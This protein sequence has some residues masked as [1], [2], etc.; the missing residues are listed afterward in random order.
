[1]RGERVLVIDVAAL[2][3]PVQ[4]DEPC[5]TNLEYDPAFGEMERSAVGRPEQQFGDKI[6]PGEEPLWRDVSRNAAGVLRRSKDLRAAVLL[7]RAELAIS[8][9]ASFTAVL[10]LIRGYIGQYWETVH[11]QLDPDDDND[12]ALRVNTL[13]SLCDD[14]ATLNLLRLTPL[15]SSRTLGRFNLRDVAVADGE[16]SPPPGVSDPPDWARINAAFSDCQA[17]DLS[18]NA[19]AVRSSLEH[20]V[21]I[22]KEFSRHVGDGNGVS[23]QPLRSQLN[24]IDKI[25]SQQ[26]A[27][28]G[29]LQPEAAATEQLSAAGMP[30]GVQQTSSGEIS[31]RDDVIATLDRICEYYAKHE[32]SSPLPLLLQRCRRLVPASFLEI[33]QDVIPEAM[34]Q[35]EAIGGRRVGQDSD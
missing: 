8:G 22:E 11:P 35:A 26:L 6:I 9:V 13:E 19:L 29:L 2:L 3:E 15:V 10:Q 1:M 17:E 7:A 28:R 34:S 16:A 23:F 30:A 31:S 20:L 24:A 5:G 12:P 21:Q 25:Y 4:P 33:I 27:R 14:E 18:T 32:P